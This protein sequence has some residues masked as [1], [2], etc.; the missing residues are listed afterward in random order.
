MGC[1]WAAGKGFGEESPHYGVEEE[2]E[3][4]EDLWYGLVKG[5]RLEGEC[6]SEEKGV[7]TARTRNS[8]TF[9]P[10]SKPIR[11]ARKVAKLV[12]TSVVVL[13]AMS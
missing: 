6:E 4:E 2:V 12:V 13:S 5:R 1:T 9:S 8:N 11:L 3:E 10:F 7:S